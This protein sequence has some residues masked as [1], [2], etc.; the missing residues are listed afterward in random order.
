MRERNEEGVGV[1][2]LLTPA[3]MIEPL[4]LIVAGILGIGAYAG[5]SL[6]NRNPGSD[7][8]ACLCLMVDRMMDVSQALPCQGSVVR[9]DC[10]H[11]LKATSSSLLPG[12][13]SACSRYVQ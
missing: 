1:S 12:H 8:T 3:L 13:K 9:I 11:D 4:P 2:L 10:A 5:L 6:G 7:R